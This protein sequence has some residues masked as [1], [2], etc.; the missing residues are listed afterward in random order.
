MPATDRFVKPGLIAEHT[1]SPMIK[2]IVGKDEPEGTSTETETAAKTNTSDVSA[3]AG[4]NTH[5]D[6]V[7]ELVAQTSPNVFYINRD[8]L[9]ENSRYFAIV[10][11]TTNTNP[12]N[13]PRTIVYLPQANVEIVKLWLD[14]VLRGEAD[15]AMFSIDNP[16]HLHECFEFA[17]FMGSYQ[18]RNQVMD[19]I[20]PMGPNKIDLKYY[21]SLLE[22]EKFNTK[23]MELFKEYALECLGYRI[24]SRG[25][26]DVAP[27]DEIGG[28][29]DGKGNGKGK[30]TPSSAS[31][32]ISGAGAGAAT[33]TGPGPDEPTSIDPALLSVINAK[34]KEIIDKEKENRMDDRRGRSYF[35][36][37]DRT[38]CTWHE[39]TDRDR[40][41]CPGDWAEKHKIGP[42]S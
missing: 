29:N 18:F 30:E 6:T 21:V 7:T 17:D 23:S 11:D 36:P 38:D 32:A 20:Q 16:D 40:V 24:A 10:L 5:T 13:P 33:W 42:R 2:I 37:D 14:S 4:A 34:I 35:P 12:S 19:A 41:K 15:K 31:F 28:A 25:W 39:H 3:G 9:I 27:K 8:F 22:N 26:V 1:H